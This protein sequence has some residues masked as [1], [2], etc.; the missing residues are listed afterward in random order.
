LSWVRSAIPRWTCTAEGAHDARK[1]HEHPVP[2]GLHDPAAV[3]GYLGVPESPA[4]GLELGQRP[5]LVSAHEATVAS[6]IS[7]QDGCEPAF[8]ALGQREPPGT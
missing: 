4:V 6:D 8:Y 3:L 2:G 1:L 5:F 7:R